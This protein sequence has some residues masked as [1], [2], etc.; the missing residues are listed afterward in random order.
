MAVP[1]LTTYRALLFLS[2]VVGLF[3]CYQTVP[4]RDKPSAKP[5]FVLVTGAL[6]YVCVKLA[7]SVVR[8]TPMVFLVTR[9]NPLGAGL[10]AAGYFLLVVEYTGIENPVSK[11]TTTGVVLVP[12]V[13]SVLVWVDLEYLWVPVDTDPGTLSGYAW[14]FTSVALGNQLYMNLLLLAGIGLLVRHAIQSPD[15]FTVQV[16]ALVLAAVGP[17]TGSVAFHLGYVPVNVVPVMFVASGALIAWAIL[18]ARFLDLIPIGRDTV[19]DQLDA[20]VVT[21][22]GEHRVVD[23]NECGCQIFDIDDAGTVVGDHIDELFADHPPFR[24]RYRTAT[25]SE[26][27]Q[28]SLLAFDGGFYTVEVVQLSPSGA[29][30]LGRSVIVRDITDQKR[31]EQELEELNTR[32]ELALE[33]TDT[34]VWE[35]D[36][37]TDEIIWDETTERLFGYDP[38]EFPGTFDAI[39]DRVHDDDI[40]EIRTAIDGALERDGEYRV[41]FRVRP[42][43]GDQRWVQTR[44]IVETEDGMPTRMLGIQTDVTDWK[45]RERELAAARESAETIIE[46]SPVPIWVQGLE[47]VRYANDAAAELF[48]FEDA[49]TLV[50]TSALSRVPEAERE[51][52]RKQNLR[53]LEDDDS[54]PATTGT[55]TT[56][57]GE[58][59]EALFAAAPIQ[60]HGE[61]SIVTIATDITE[62]RERERELRK[63]KTQLEQSNEKLEQF[64]GVVSHDLRNPLNVIAGHVRLID[65]DGDGGEHLEAIERSVTRME[66]MITDLLALSRA[67]QSIE[68]AET[69]SLAAVATASWDTVET[70]GA[71]LDLRVP[72]NATVSADRDRLMNVFENLFRNAREHNE[73]PLGIRVGVLDS[74]TADDDSESLAGF[75]V[76]DDGDGIPEAERDEIFDHGYTTNTD[77]TGFGLSIVEGVVEAHGWSLSL[78]EG[79]DGGARF[80]ITT[81]KST[82]D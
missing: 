6:L 11:R 75:F 78:C 47:E 19:L 17:L 5:L 56:I 16:S 51:Q 35:W 79:E 53:M 77:G 33:E 61:R 71:D 50:G 72:E 2:V 60:Y 64:A 48:G 3:L 8:G 41:A 4:Y 52:A 59:R 49:S 29:R 32:F 66:D 81:S 63:T 36:L 45:R 38:G 80:E 9:F 14:E 15:R 28:D 58:S 70:D 25:A 40:L 39:A 54:F 68:T 34:G 55:L 37:E 42:P 20:G 69:M 57:D 13:V 67:G 76:E 43:D 44:G 73:P 82:T 74:A 27:E 62:R 22:D 24:E 31:R 12:A 7:V 30:T 26:A 1:W 21:L 65:S 46:A 18:R 23:I 10:A